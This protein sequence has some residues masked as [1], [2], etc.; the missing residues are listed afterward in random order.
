[1]SYTLTRQHTLKLS[2]EVKTATLVIVGIT[3]FIFGFNY[4]KSNNL[5]EDSKVL[6]ATYKDVSGVDKSTPVKVNG[7]T[8]GKV[9]GI[10]L[11]EDNSGKVIVALNLNTNFQF[12]KNSLALLQDDGL[13]GGKNIAIIPAMDNA[14]MAENGDMLKAKIKSSLTE[15]FGSSL[16]P[17]QN[18]LE[19]VLINTDTLLSSF[20]AIF[21][22]KTQSDLK[23][24][25]GGL[26][27]TVSSFQATSNSLNELVKGNQS[28]LNSTLTS[29]DVMSKN[30]SKVTASLSKADLGATVVKLEGTLNNLNKLLG[31]VQNG[32]GSMGKL[33]KDE[34]LYSN[35]E[36][37][38][39]QLEQLLQDMKLNPKRYMHFSVFGKKAKR[40]DEKGNEIKETN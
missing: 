23:R 5:L 21:D 31:G 15:V 2:R 6:Y 30:L 13:I 24:T 35:L 32:N 34:K 25:I 14:P 28:K 12:S 7:V 19:R 9:S 27:G 36:G 1:M 20:N 8:I 40:Y 38:S 17:L 18:K 29:F 39:K 4:L 10:S 16:S 11:A 3:L 37:A 26:N 22:A 33:L